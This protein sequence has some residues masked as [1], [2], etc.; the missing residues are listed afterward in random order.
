MLGRT[1]LILLLITFAIAG[2]RIALAQESS[3]EE[4]DIQIVDFKW[5]FD[6]YSRYKTFVPLRIVI[7]NRSPIEKS[8]HMQLSRDDSIHADGEVLEQ[9]IVL[10][11]ETTRVL[12]M[13]PF[14][15]DPGETWTLRWGKSEEESL[16][17]KGQTA[18]DGIVFITSAT[19]LIHRSGSLPVMKDDE[20]P[21]SVT[22]LDAL[23][24]VLLDQEP[25]WSGARRKAFQ[26]WLL[27][28]GKVVVLDQPDGTRPSSPTGSSS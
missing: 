19:D 26:E 8:L 4:E 20:F 12:Q 25:R 27:K 10:S 13:T 22:A 3:P 24:V 23:R 18:D 5:G 7:K 14:V 1:F 21:T 15:S 2:D 6:G 16:S 11:P 9:D 17:V 28:G